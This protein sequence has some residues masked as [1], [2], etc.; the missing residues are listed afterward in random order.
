[1]P[2]VTDSCLD[3]AL[4]AM[5]ER[6]MGCESPCARSGEVPGKYA[7][8]L[9]ATDD[10]ALV[11][12]T[13]GTDI[14]QTRIRPPLTRHIDHNQAHLCPLHALTYPGSTGIVPNPPNYTLFRPESTH[15]IAG[16]V[17]PRQ[18]LSCARR[19]NRIAVGWFG[20][21]SGDRGQGVGWLVATLQALLAEVAVYALVPSLVTRVLCTAWL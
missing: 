2:P 20:L 6:Q 12:C 17:E 16:Y 4:G 21:R 13:V 14:G 5:C 15:M 9:R 7:L 19:G 10:R 8:S 11:T 3:G 18:L 1:M